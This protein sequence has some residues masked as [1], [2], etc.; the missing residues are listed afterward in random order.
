MMWFSMKTTQD[1]FLQSPLAGV[2]FWMEKWNIV[3]IYKKATSSISKII[4][5]FLYF[6]FEK[7]IEK[8][9]FLTKCL[10][11]FSLISLYQSCL[12]K[13]DSCVKQLLSISHGIYTLLDR[14]E[15]RD[16]FLDISKA[17]DKVW[18]EGL[19]LRLK[20]NG[21]SAEL[22]HILSGFFQ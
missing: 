4:I 22:L 10:A 7:K 16:V 15:V 11:L 1:D 19:V 13:G 3:L 21:I 8:D 18:H 5:Q 6:Q 20:Q 2:S 17:F 14:L 9:L 12:K